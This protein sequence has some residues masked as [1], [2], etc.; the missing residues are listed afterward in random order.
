MT[1]MVALRAPFLTLTRCTGHFAGTRD[2][3]S[4]WGV[5][6]RWLFQLPRQGVDAMRHMESAP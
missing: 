4:P 3:A 1:E 2:G 6:I 5:D